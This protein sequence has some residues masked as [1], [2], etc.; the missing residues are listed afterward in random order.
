MNADRN[1][2]GFDVARLMRRDLRDME[3]Y[4]VPFR[5]GPYKL[6]SNESPFGLPDALRRRLIAWLEDE[7]NEDLHLYPDGANTRLRGALAELW[8]VAPENVTCGV[9]SDQ[10]I[11]GI[12][13]VFLE[14]GDGV[15]VLKPT[16][17]MYAV[18]ARLNHGKVRE[19]PLRD[20]DVAEIVRAASDPRVKVVFLCSPNNP[21]GQSLTEGEICS[22]LSDVRCLVVVDEAYGEFARPTMIPRIRDYPNMIV[23][24]TFSKAFGLAGARVGYAVAA[25][26]AID[27]L[28]RAKPPF[29]LPTL[30][31]L[32]ATWAIEEWQEY[33]VRVAHLNERREELYRE[34]EKIPWLEVS[35]SDAN[36][37]LVRSERDVGALLEENGIFVRRYPGADRVTCTRISVG[38]AEQNGKVVEV[39]CGAEPR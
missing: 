35:R 30:S 4:A 19:V 16:F 20:G 38:T 21:T 3:N 12:C 24:R 33:S 28:D 8:G 7:K 22:V 15:V 37:L 14:P 9:G 27:A 25:A 17:G 2:N 31:Q 10:L 18:S 1:Q 26:E 39:L 5:R 34:L 29:N 11:D 13:R 32:L 36:F 6:D 23:L